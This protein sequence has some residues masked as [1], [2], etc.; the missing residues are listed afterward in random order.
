LPEGAPRAHRG[1]VRSD[2][3]DKATEMERGQP[4]VGPYPAPGLIRRARRM[5]DMSQREFARAA[6]VSQSTVAR[7]ESG[8][9][10]PSLD[11]MQ[12]LLSVAGLHLVVVDDEGH[13]VLPM[14]ESDD[15]RDGNRRRYPSHLDTILDPRAGEWWA[16]VY[17]LARPPETFYRDRRKRDYMRA[18]SRW[19]VRVAQLRDEPPPRNPYAAAEQQARW[20]RIREEFRLGIRKAPEINSDEYDDID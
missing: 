14:R 17:G 2:W 9:L 19:E 10:K 1:G 7:L 6:K 16:D 11:V 15:V 5:V 4:R 13:V 8:A 12:T 20:A 3:D 18:R